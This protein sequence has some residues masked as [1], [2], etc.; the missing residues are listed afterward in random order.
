MPTEDLEMILQRGYFDI[1]DET[2]CQR[3]ADDGLQL[4]PRGL[5]LLRVSLLMHFCNPSP[6]N[7]VRSV[8][9]YRECALTIKRVRIWRLMDEAHKVR[10]GRLPADAMEIAKAAREG[11][12]EELHRATAARLARAIAWQSCSNI[13][14]VDFR[15]R[16]RV[17]L[18]LGE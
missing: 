10:T 9:S 16:E 6:A 2:Y 15:S 18:K 12:M 7:A 3:E 5:R 11:G 17:S 8:A 13:T 14:Y 1:N 4:L